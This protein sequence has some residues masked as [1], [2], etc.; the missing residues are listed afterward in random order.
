MGLFVTQV[1]CPPIVCTSLACV[2][3]DSVLNTDNMSIMGI[4]IDYGPY[5]FM[6]R[7]DP[8]HICNGSGIV[9]ILVIML[10]LR[11]YILLYLL[12]SFYC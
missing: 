12:L 4:T 11:L 10:L 9:L 5:G 8:R 6:D 7:F 2:L 3:I 1:I